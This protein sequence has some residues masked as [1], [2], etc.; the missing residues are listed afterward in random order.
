MVE[1]SVIM[2]AFRAR[3]T[4]AAAIASVARQGIA[5]A[6][7]EIVIAADDGDD[8]RDLRR[9]WPNCRFAPRWHWRSGP[10]AAR[11]RAQARARGRF[12]AYLDADDTWSEGYLAALLPLARR[13][14]AAMAATAVIGARGTLLRLGP[15]RGRL[16]LRDFG[17]WPGSFHPLVARDLN[18]DFR[19]GPAQDVLH[20]MEVMGRLGGRLPLA[21]G[22]SYQLRL[23]AGSV[24]ANPAFGRRVDQQYRRMARLIRAGETA[25][26]GAGRI[27]A[28]AALDQRQRWNRAWLASEG[29]RDGFYGFLA[30]HLDVK[31]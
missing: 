31:K 18:L 15:D 29:D 13:H 20:A 16:E 17:H 12:I 23:R 1:V 30:R 27:A 22:A 5:P 10:G 26:T 6:Q 3:E 19:H 8:Y 25:I 14:G 11:N 9:F 28:L 7:L 4:I 2:P 21:E 24:T